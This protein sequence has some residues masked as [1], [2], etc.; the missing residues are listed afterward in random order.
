MKGTKESQ[1]YAK[2]RYKENSPHHDLNYFLLFFVHPPVSGDPLGQ[3]LTDSIPVL[4][5]TVFLVYHWLTGV[6]RSL[7]GCLDISVAITGC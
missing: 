1:R 6:M 2:L 7:S 4:L 3:M 5:L